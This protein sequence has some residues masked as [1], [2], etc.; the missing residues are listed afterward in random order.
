MNFLKYNNLAH[1]YKKNWFIFVQ[2]HIKAQKYDY[3]DS[4]LNVS[5]NEIVKNK[6]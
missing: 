1:L 4:Y 5:S 3:L 6:K 2:K